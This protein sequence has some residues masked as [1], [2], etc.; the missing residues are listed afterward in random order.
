MVLACVGLA[1]VAA[2]SLSR[3]DAATPHR[4]GRAGAAG[5]VQLDREEPLRSKMHE[6]RDKM[7]ENMQQLANKMKPMN[8]ED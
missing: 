7:Q 6:A 3:N 4:G 8:R 5:V 2:L 1:A